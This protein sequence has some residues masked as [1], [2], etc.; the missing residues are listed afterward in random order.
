MPRIVR[1]LQRLFSNMSPLEA[2][3]LLPFGS[4]MDVAFELY[5]DPSDMY[6]HDEMPD[7]TG[8]RFR[9]GMVPEIV[10]W[11][12]PTAIEAIVYYSDNSNPGRD[13]AAL[14]DAYGEGQNWRTVNEGYLYFRADDR[15]RLTCSAVPIYAVCTPEYFSKESKPKKDGDDDESPNAD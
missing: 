3:E 12:S 10:I 15:L 14:M 1:W 6:E 4:T 9:E 7:I 11:A 2:I 13:L 5:G 8:L